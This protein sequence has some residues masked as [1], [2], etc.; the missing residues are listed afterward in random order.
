MIL[1]ILLISSSKIDFCADM[2]RFLLIQFA[3]R[4]GH[5]VKVVGNIREYDNKIHMSIFEAYLVQ[6]WNELT[7]HFLD[8]IFTHLQNT[9]G[10]IPVSHLRLYCLMLISV[11][12]LCHREVKKSLNLQLV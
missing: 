6:D 5:L 1:L 4:A 7:H 2:F 9:K 11:W 3:F 12:N 10:P 8:T